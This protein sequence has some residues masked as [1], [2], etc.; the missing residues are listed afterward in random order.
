MR[1][2]RVMRK[3]RIV[4]AI[5]PG[6]AERPRA[7]LRRRRRADVGRR[8]D[9]RREQLVLEHV[10]RAQL[11]IGDEGLSRGVRNGGEL[12]APADPD[13]ARFVGP[14][15]VES[16]MSGAIAR[17]NRIG[18]S[19]A[20]NGFC[21]TFQSS[22]PSRS[23]LPRIPRSGINGTPFSLACNAVC[24]AGQVASRTTISPFSAA[25]LKRGA[26]PA[27]PSETALD[28][29]SRT[30]PAPISRSAHMPSTGTPRSFRFFFFSRTR[31]RT[32]AM[33]GIE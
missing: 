22:R 31:A 11:F 3:V 16:A 32:T 8:D 10:A 21:K 2:A 7:A 4:D 9:A 28:S 26:R 20:A 12:A 14:V 5:D 29:T 18:S 6:D 30:Q 33:A 17:T 23:S 27:S 19:V 1:A 24:T 25:S 15:R 13:V